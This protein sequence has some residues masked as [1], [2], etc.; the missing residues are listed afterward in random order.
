MEIAEIISK[1][2]IDSV[3]KSYRILTLNDR[4][5]PTDIASHKL[6]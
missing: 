5:S 6:H 2:I 4:R 1:V 3:H